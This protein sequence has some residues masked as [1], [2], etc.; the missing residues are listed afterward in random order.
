MNTRGFVFVVALGALPQA[1]L[2]D[3]TTPATPEDAPTVPSPSAPSTT[4]APAPSATGGTKTDTSTHYL[5]DGFYLRYALGPAYWQVSGS[6][7]SGAFSASGGSA[8]EILAIGGTIPDGVVIGGAAAASI[9]G[10]SVVGNY[11]LFVDWFPNARGG[12]HAGGLVG[13][14]LLRLRSGY[15]AALGVDPH[16][17]LGGSGLGATLLGGYDFWITPQCSLGLTAIAVTMTASNAQ[18]ASGTTLTPLWVGAFASVL[19][20]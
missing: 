18:E 13:L 10:D 7:P 9:S 16:Q 12:F 20:H 6:S 3:T 4:P 8:G 19:Y 14:G 2:A 5:H 15:P 1:A 17:G 11:G